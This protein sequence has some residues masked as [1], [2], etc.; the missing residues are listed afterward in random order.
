M[1]SSLSSRIGSVC[2]L[3]Q[4]PGN[5]FA[6][7]FHFNLS[8]F[9]ACYTCFSVS[10]PLRV[11]VCLLL[12]FV[13]VFVSFSIQNLAQLFALLL[14]CAL[15]LL[16]FSFPLYIIAAVYVWL[17]ARQLPLARPHHA[18]IS[19]SHHY[20]SLSF[21]GSSSLTMLLLLL[22]LLNVFGARVHSICCCCCCCHCFCCCKCYVY[23]PASK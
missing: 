13:L 7:C 6:V 4:H 3:L 8:K 18:P 15:S 16:L 21:K 5:I 22:C 9:Y 1:P 19:L 17:L 20:I 11:W 23:M 12:L 14:L 10:V 2:H